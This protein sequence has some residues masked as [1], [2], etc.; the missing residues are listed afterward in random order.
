MS[1]VTENRVREINT[2]N[3]WQWYIISSFIHFELWV[4]FSVLL[5]SLILCFPQSRLT[6]KLVHLYLEKNC[7]TYLFYIFFWLPVFNNL[8]N[9]SKTFLNIGKLRYL[10]CVF[11]TYTEIIHITGCWFSELILTTDC[12]VSKKDS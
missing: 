7:Q 5:K 1:K 12:A 9:S 8:P 10:D 11:G 4:H 6:N 2:S 3:V